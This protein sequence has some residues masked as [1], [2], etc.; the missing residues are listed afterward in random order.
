LVACGWFI[1]TTYYDEQII[2]RHIRNQEN[3][4]KASDFADLFNPNYQP[5][6]KALLVF[7]TLTRRGG[8]D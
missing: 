1:L 7:Q 2:R 5:I 4:D 3:L 8:H 6:A